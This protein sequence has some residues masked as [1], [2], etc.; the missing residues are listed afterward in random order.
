MINLWCKAP[1]HVAGSLIT[2]AAKKET[3]GEVEFPETGENVLNTGVK[4]GVL[5]QM[6]ALC[7]LEKG[8]FACSRKGALP[9]QQKGHPA[10]IL[11]FPLE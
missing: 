6:A 11:I 5:A 10:G 3:C 4:L 2:R 1:P 8:T 9:L 7:T